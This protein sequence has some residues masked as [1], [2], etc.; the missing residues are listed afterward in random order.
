MAKRDDIINTASR[1]FNYYGI[2]KT[3]LNDVAKAIN[4][5]TPSIY[6]YFK[7]KGE[8]TSAVVCQIVDESYKKIVVNTL[9]ADNIKKSI[10]ALVNE[11]CTD[12][13]KHFNLYLSIPY[14]IRQ[15]YYDCVYAN[16]LSNKRRILEIYSALVI[17]EGDKIGLNARYTIFGFLDA[18]DDNFGQFIL[19]RK[20]PRT[21]ESL[22]QMLDEQ[23]NLS[24]QFLFKSF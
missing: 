22:N 12:I 17:D 14:L 4:S 5:S 3:T 19:G 1:L 10:I 13:K 16:Y 7:D 8:L 2:E 21:K 24:Q 15:G 11:K 6:Y 9:N 23:L 18:I 20:G